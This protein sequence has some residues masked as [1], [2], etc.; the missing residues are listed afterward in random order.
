MYSLLKMGI[1]QPAMFDYRSVATQTNFTTCET[2]GFVRP[3]DKMDKHP[4]QKQPLVVPQAE[5]RQ[6]LGP[7]G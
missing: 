3:Q 7:L 4:R 2:A 6:N 1:F 5:T